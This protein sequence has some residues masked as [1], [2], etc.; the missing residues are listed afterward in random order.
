M[1]IN[2]NNLCDN[3]KEIYR[4]KHLF[5]KCIALSQTSGNI[6]LNWYYLPTESNFTINVVNALF[7]ITPEDNQAAHRLICK[8]NHTMTVAKMSISKS[9]F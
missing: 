7:D 5:F 8:A 1:K 9:R 3:C 6:S 4:L 2:N